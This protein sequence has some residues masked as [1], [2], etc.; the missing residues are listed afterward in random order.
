[1]KNNKILLILESHIDKIVLAVYVLVSLLLLWVYVVSNPYGETVRIQGR[2]KKRSPSE[3]DFAINTEAKEM[4]PKLDRPA[5]PLPPIKSYL[6]E[7]DQLLRRSFSV[8]SSVQIPSPGAGDAVIEEDRLY[9]LPEIPSLAE[10]TAGNLR[11]AARVPTGEVAP[12]RPYPSVEGEVKDVDFVTVSARFDV[13]RLYYNFQQSFAGPRLK[14]SWK[15]PVLATPV[16]ADI[17]LQRRTQQ[18][19]GSWGSWGTVPRTNIDSYRD[20]LEELPLTL[21]QSQ[22][23]VDL[24]MPQYQKQDIQYDILQPAN[25]TYTVSRLEWMPPTFVNEAL[26]I[27][28]KQEEKEK[29]ERQEE[30]RNRTTGANTADNR[31]GGTTTRRRPTATGRR[32]NTPGGRR[33]GDMMMAEGMYGEALT[34]RTPARKEREIDDVM[35]DF[36]KELL[37][38]KKTIEDVTEPLLVWVHDDTVDPGETYQY[39]L[40]I[41]IFNPIA[42]KDWFQDDQVQYKNQMVLWSAY[43]EP[44]EALHIDKRIYIFPVGTLGDKKTPDVI[45]GVKV[46]VAKYYLGQ[47]RDFDFDV[48][49]GEIIGYEVEDKQ[50]DDNLQNPMIENYDAM[51]GMTE[52]SGKVDFTTDITL[53]DVVKDIVWGSRLRSD[54]LYTMLYFE[55]D[56]LQ[57]IPIGKNN[58]NSEIRKIYADIQDAMDQDVQR[59]N[60]GMM[61]MGPDMMMDPG[62]MMDPMMGM[63]GMMP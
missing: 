13:Q 12:D 1:M 62:M 39:R 50:E 29:R 46:Q 47:W 25:Y 14:T 41:G 60:P 38:E 40:R 24:L 51:M 36:K 2:E 49:N 55:S 5:P 27:L 31:R 9:A 15:D 20:L 45:E 7:Y 28:K 42:G 16:F 35:K 32:S 6:P 11:G 3:I 4:I 26:D 30:L 54:V 37:D 48:Y 53:V 22:F 17:E 18:D 63:P 33:G 43:S 57:Q 23:S 10:V 21:D 52:D 44:T 19:D 61:E 59:R 34:P 58:W 56:R 8:S